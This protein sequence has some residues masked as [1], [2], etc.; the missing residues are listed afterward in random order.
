[1]GVRFIEELPITGRRTFIRVDLDVPVKDGQVVDDARVRA[2]LPT[3][4]HAVARGARVILASHLGRPRGKVHEG[5]RLEPVGARLAELLELD[6]IAADDCVGDGVRKLAQDLRDGQV[7]LLENLRFRREEEENEPA[8][9]E[10]LASLAEVYVHDAFACAHRPSASGV[11]MLRHVKQRGVGYQMRKELRFLGEALS[12]PSRPFVAVVGGARLS[13]RLGLLQSLLGRADAVLVGGGLAFTCLRARGLGVGASP[14]EPDRERA[15]ADLLE[16]ARQR[17]VELLLPEDHLVASGPEDAAGEALAGA[18]PDGRVGLDIGP[19]TL[20]R[21]GEALRAARTVFWCGPMGVFE[22]PAFAAGTL[23]IARAV[24]GAPGVSVVSGRQASAALVQAGVA[25][26]VSHVSTGGGASLE[27]VEG[28]A[29][30]GVVALE[31]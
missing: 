4:R 9:A 31:S 5:L 8:F 24:A 10:R 21:Y 20:A 13:E 16:A 12:R 18:I 3:I 15:A 25:D 11:G 7:L 23:G 28:R 2:A 27:L 17:K 30:P 19:R 26:E 22:R 6:I 14:V 1:M 29:L